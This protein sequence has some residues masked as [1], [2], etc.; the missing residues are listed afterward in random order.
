MRGLQ[1]GYFVRV[2]AIDSGMSFLL[3]SSIPSVLIG[4]CLVLCEYTA[5]F[6]LVA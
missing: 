1:Q 5:L 6:G 2:G 4:L 3:A